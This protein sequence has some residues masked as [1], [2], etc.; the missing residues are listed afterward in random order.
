MARVLI[1]EDDPGVAYT[2]RAGLAGAGH[3]VEWKPDGLAALEALKAAR[4]SFD[5]VITDL[6]MPKLDGL[7]LLEEVRAAWPDLAVVLIT[8]VGDE[9][10]AVQA[11]KAGALDYFKKPFD[12]DEVEAVVERAAEAASLRRELARL[13]SRAEPEAVFTSPA[14]LKVREL[15]ERVADKDVT[16]LITGET[17]TGK[18][19]VAD[20]VQ[21]RSRRAGAAYVKLHC[22]AI[23]ET[24]AESELFGH[25]RGAF[26]GAHRQHR[27]AFQRAHGGTLLLDEIGDVPLSV[28]GKLLRAVQQGELQPLGAEALAKVDVRLI[29]ATRRD[30]ARESA[31][32]RFREDLYFR[33][34]VVHLRVPPLRERREDVAPMARR[35]LLLATLKLSGPNATPPEIDPEAMELLVRRDWPGNARELQN[36]VERLVAL[37]AGPLIGP[38]DVAMLDGAPERPPPSPGGLREKVAAFERELVERA[39]AE[40]GGNQSEAARRLGLSRVTLLDKLRRLGL[41]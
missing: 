25:E 14:M 32:G 21:S 20:L 39:L 7:Q 1:A 38:E 10:K 17:G 19:V 9:R 28:Q 31:E 36:A 6:M 26:T 40:S 23:P 11:M 13:R 24:L 15:A 41:R 34:N 16:V 8:A 29:A 33:L 5:V 30:L 12:L 4:E 2:L 22:G 35:F 27:G 18:E 37:A 3:A